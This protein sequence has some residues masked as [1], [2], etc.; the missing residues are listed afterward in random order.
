MTESLSTGVRRGEVLSSLSMAPAEAVKGFAEELIP[1]LGPIEVLVNRTGLVM[2]P[3]V[4]TAKGT[5]FYVGE[6]LVAE[7]RVRLGGAEGYAA[8]LGRDLQQA[9]ALALI[10]GAGA[11]G[12][13]ADRISAFVL[14]QSKYLAEADELLLRQ[15]EAT[16]VRMETF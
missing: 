2:L 11:A 5:T 16:R 1:E 7:A 14:E 9:L 3:M 6:V 12:M 8:C 4:E 13:A 15:V 10:D